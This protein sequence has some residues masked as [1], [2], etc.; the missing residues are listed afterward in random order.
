MSIEADII[1]DGKVIMALMRCDGIEVRERI[2]RQIHQWDSDRQLSYLDGVN[3][4]LRAKLSRLL[5]A[6]GKRAPP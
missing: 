5:A 6:K 3:K 1:E 2:G 4:R